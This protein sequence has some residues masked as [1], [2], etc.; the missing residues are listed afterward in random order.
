MIRERLPDATIITF[1]HIPWPNSEVFGICPWRERDPRGHARQLDP[2][3]PHPVPLQQLHRTRRPLPRSAHRPRGLRR[4]PTAARR[5]WC[6]PIRS[7]SSG[8]AQRLATPTPE[9][10]RRARAASATACRRTCK[11]GVGVDR[12]D[13]TKGILERFARARASCFDQHPTGSA[14]SRFLQIAAP[15]RASARRLPAAASGVRCDYV[16]AHQRALRQRRLPADHP[17]RRAPRASDDVYELYRAADICVVSSL[18][19]GMNLVAKEF[20]AA[21]DDEQGVLVLSPSPAPRANCSRR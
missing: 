18:H 14:A 19:D 2:R 1:W 15:S 16:G 6:T 10:A 17:A 9:A 5:R 13:Y 11:L 12:L 21:R 20:V 7:R 8:R 3:L 4:S